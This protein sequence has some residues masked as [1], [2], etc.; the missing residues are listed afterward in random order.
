MCWSQKN[1]EKCSNLAYYQGIVCGV[2]SKNK[3][4][5]PKNPNAKEAKNQLLLNRSAMVEE[6]ARINR[7]AGQK[8]NV[9][10][11]KMLMMKNPEHIDG[12]LKI[13]PN[14]KHGSRKDGLG[15]PTLSPKSIGPIFHGQPN[16]PP[17]KNLEN[18][19]QG[20]KIFKEEI[21]A[22]RNPSA[23]FVQHRLEMYLDSFP[24][25]HKYEKYPNLTTQ[26]NKNIPLYSVWIEADG[27]E[28]HLTYFESRQIYC[29]IYESIVRHLP[30][31]QKLQQFIS[32]G[33]NLQIFG[34]DAYPITKS[35]E[36]HYLDTSR[37]F[38]H[39]L[40]L[41]SMLVDQY[42]WRKYVTLSNIF[43]KKE[44]EQVLLDPIEEQ[45]TEEQ[46]EQEETEEKQKS[47]EKKRN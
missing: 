38:G 39:E 22:N 30:D 45:E 2:H 35:L 24:W 4:P 23:L 25:R 17:A 8:G 3:S 34:Y 12:Y 15:L 41:Y 19:H 27:S 9:I 11:S 31:F 47:P 32:N 10:L 46:Q 6:T 16:L 21:D 13:F 7:E 29:S 14:F 36:G 26:K 33:Y 20:N 40:V 18:L 28:K 42:P 44:Q 43:S 5:L 37:P 1:G